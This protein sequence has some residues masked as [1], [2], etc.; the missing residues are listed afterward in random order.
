MF[1]PIQGKAIESKDEKKKKG[2]GKEKE[3]VNTAEENLNQVV[4][5]THSTSISLS[6]YESQKSE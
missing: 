3:K 4:E 6:K 5:K 2:K 1:M